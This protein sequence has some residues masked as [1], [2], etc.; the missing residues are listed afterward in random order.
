MATLPSKGQWD[1]WDGT[2]GLSQWLLSDHNADGSHDFATSNVI[3][4]YNVKSVTYGAAGDGVADD[5]AECQAAIDACVAAGGGY[6]Y[7][8]EGTYN[9]TG[10]TLGD[11]VTLIGDGA[12]S[13]II[14]YTPATGDCID[15]DNE[16][17]I[18]II[19]LK[20]S[21]NNSSTGWGIASDATGAS[22]DIT[23][24]KYEIEGFLGGIKI[25]WGIQVHIGR[26]RLIGQGKAVANGIG[27][28]L[29]HLTNASPVVN[30]THLHGAYASGYENNFHIRSTVAG[31]SYCTSES[32][33]TA[34][35]WTAR[36]H[37]ANS[38]IQGDTYLLDP[39]VAGTRVSVIGNV[40]YNGASVEQDWNSTM[41]NMATTESFGWHN[42]G[43]AT[44]LRLRLR[45]FSATGD[46]PGIEGYQD[47]LERFVIEYLNATGL[48]IDSDTV[49]NLGTGSNITARIRN[50]NLEVGPGTK[51]DGHITKAPAEVQ[52]TDATQTTVDSVTLLDENTYHVEA[53]VVGVKSDGS[54]RASYHIT[55]T[56]YRTGAGNAT[57]QGAVTAVHSQESNAAWDATFTVSGNDIR[58]SVTGVAAT[59]I[60]WGCTL[61]Y[62]NMSN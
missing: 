28:Q 61:K 18:N 25:E 1:W 58:V 22:G 52:T 37:I 24:D 35:K 48:H 33:D 62:I 45:S 41:F 38:W 55:A 42:G 23:I 20:I 3:P 53:W 7:F 56:V 13:S 34:V 27:I 30:T 19:G 31:M 15:L 17:V 8:P 36:L 59:T 26:G 47:T 51:H 4:V 10:L 32:C 21:S 6:V 14:Q 60:E 16:D 54:D 46:I 5:T 12:K 49:I 29:G 9:N 57:L 50:N 2:N 43:N 44:L 11:N 40:F 39:L